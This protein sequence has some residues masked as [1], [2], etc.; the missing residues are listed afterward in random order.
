MSP[1]GAVGLLSYVGEDVAGAAQFVLP[2]RAAEVTT[3]G[4]VEMVDVDYIEERLRTLRTD[5]AAW[6][7]TH[8]P[9]QLSLAGAQ[10]KFALY[11]DEDGKWGLPSGRTPTTHILKPPLEHLAGQEINEY[12]CLQAARK[13]GMASANSEVMIFGSEAAV[14]IERYDR[15]R[16][17]VG[18][19][20]I[21]VH[22]EDFCQA[23]GVMPER[24][25]QRGDNGPG[26]HQVIELIRK[27]QDRRIAHTSINT[28]V[29]ARAYNWVILGPDAQAKNY[30]LLLS[31]NEVRL[32]PLYDISSVASYPTQFDLATMAMAMS[33]GGRF[34]NAL[35]T[36]ERWDAFADDN[37]LD[38]EEVA[39]LVYDVA[40]R[41][42]DAVRDVITAAPKWA[43]QS[44]VARDLLEGVARSAR[45]RLTNLR[46]PVIR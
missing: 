15:V 33:I 32:A 43:A 31:G 44:K 5:R 3:S 6:R 26:A 34:E 2:E 28:F 45:D 7:D 24:K 22:Q 36:S 20:I 46:R 16:P 23:L 25:Y 37:R 21:R 35:V 4:A 10:A 13:L 9:G 1:N 12:L 39:E 19:A 27:V 40:T 18:A 8:A 14:V 38:R 11:R 29:R 17:G 30:S 42:P 41:V